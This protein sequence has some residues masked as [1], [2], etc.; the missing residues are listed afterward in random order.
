MTH[1]IHFV[2]HNVSWP[3]YHI[4]KSGPEYMITFYKVNYE[5]INAYDGEIISGR[6]FCIFMFKNI[7][8]KNKFYLTN[9]HSSHHPN[10]FLSIIKPLENIIKNLDHTNV[11]EFIL[12]GDFNRNMCK[13]ISI[14]SKNYIFKLKNIE[15]T[16]NTCCDDN[17]KSLKY[18]YDHILCSS[19]PIKKIIYNNFTPASDHMMVLVELKDL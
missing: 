17:M 16:E 2:C 9:I 3:N 6:P 4:N 13:N 14:T 7:I 19:K 10:T 1:E 11:S 5:K 8:L 15:N 18:N 12:G